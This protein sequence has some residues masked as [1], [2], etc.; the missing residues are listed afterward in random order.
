MILQMFKCTTYC[1]QYLE[2]IRNLTSPDRKKTWRNIHAYY[3]AN[4]YERN[5][6]ECISAAQYVKKGKIKPQI[7]LHFLAGKQTMLSYYAEKVLDWVL[8]I[9]LHSQ[10]LTKIERKLKGM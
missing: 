2:A 5:F 6:E 7:I 9:T 4:I 3:E 8:L 10:T 1:K